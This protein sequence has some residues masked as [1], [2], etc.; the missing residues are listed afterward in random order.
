MGLFTPAA[1]AQPPAGA[2]IPA[3][4]VNAPSGFFA[5]GGGY[6][7]S[8]LLGLSAAALAVTGPGDWS[9]D[10]RLGHGHQP[11]V[12]GGR[13][14]CSLPQR[15]LPWFLQRRSKALTGPEPRACRRKRYDAPDAGTMS[16]ETR[17]ASV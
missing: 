4:A 14:P 2:M 7:Y 9:L 12:D 1:S 11:A 3:W 5:T 15:P 13:P 17:V 16:P 10:A 6:E 8:A